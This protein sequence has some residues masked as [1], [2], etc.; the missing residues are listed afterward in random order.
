MLKG[1]GLSLRLFKLA[2]PSVKILCNHEH[3]FATTTETGTESTPF[4]VESSL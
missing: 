3:D 2:T 1:Q 4:A